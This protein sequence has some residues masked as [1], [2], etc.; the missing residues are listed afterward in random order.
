MRIAYFDC[1]SGISGPMALAALVDA[2]ADLGEIAGFL[3]ALPIG[4]FSVE[5]ERVE[6]RGI[7]ATHVDVEAPPQEVIRTYTSMRALLEASDLPDEPKRLAQRTYRLL[8]EAAGRVH[9]KEPDL[10]AFHEW[11]PLDCVIDIVGPALALDMLG[12]DRVFASPVPTGMGM[13]RTEHGLTPIPSPVVLELLRGAPTYS[14]G[15]PVELVTPTG[16]ALLAAIVEGY[17]DL[18]L[19]RSDR[20]GYGA[21]HLRMDFP[22]ALRVVIGQQEQRTGAGAMAGG[23]AFEDVLLEASFDNA[24]LETC[25][26]LMDRMVRAGAWDAWVTTAMGR[27]GRPRLIVSA[28]GPGSLADEIAE[29]L[30]SEPGAGEVRR[31]PASQG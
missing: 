10:V 24:E 20:V 19:M 27:G 30:G 26:R 17:G 2:G 4:S 9:E 22:N 12:I 14:R 21:G 3:Q 16:A 28:V 13:A 31:S 18:P 25:E 1:F 11:G 7:R 5:A 29:V 15:V 8:A 23:G 6:V